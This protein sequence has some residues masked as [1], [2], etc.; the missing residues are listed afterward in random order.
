MWVR[1]RKKILL[2]CLSVVLLAACI[3]GIAALVQA[4]RDAKDAK[5]HSHGSPALPSDPMER[6]RALMAITPLL[7]A[8]NDL[9]YKVR[10]DDLLDLN[11]V[12]L[13]DG[14]LPGYQTTIPAIRSGLLGAQLWSVYTAC[15]SM[16]KDAVRQT[17]EAM[18]TVHMMVEKYPSVFGLADSSAQIRQ[19]FAEGKVAS[20]MGAEGG[21]QIDS[22]IMALRQM[23]RGGVRYMTLTHN[24]NP[25]DPDQPW[26]GSCCP[27]AG[28][29]ANLGL[30]DFGRD[31]VREMNAVGMLV[32]ISHTSVETMEDVLEVTLAP[33]IFSHSNAKALCD[34][35]RNVPDHILDALAAAPHGGGVICMNF[36]PPFL[37]VT[38][39]AV[40]DVNTVA[41][42][43]EYIT[44]RIGWQYI[45]IGSDFDGVGSLPI[46][47]QSPADYPNLFAELIRRGFTDQMIR[48]ILSENLMRVLDAADTVAAQLKASTPPLY[49]LTRPFNDTC[50]NFLL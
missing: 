3:S 12:D 10:E 1:H 30:S 32:D 37:N 4:S 41:N 9:P 23:R 21:H 20:L 45:G 26:A 17:L 44:Q 34:V 29:P 14:G 43:I 18:D 28:H 49:T 48:G 2:A 42:H 35:P 33:P 22:S 36:Y 24:C 6:A 5:S 7:D 8:H 25:G 50:R 16:Q 47:L 27:P 40:V 31:V 38:A 15:S 46:G 13:E 19:V 11:S 39:G